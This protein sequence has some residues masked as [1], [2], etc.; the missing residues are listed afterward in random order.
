[1]LGFDKDNLNIALK[2]FQ[3]DCKARRVNKI[4]KGVCKKSFNYNDGYKFFTLNF[5]P[6]KLLN[7]KQKD[8]GLIT[9]YYEPILNGS[10][11]KTAK[12]KYPIYKTP[13]D[14]ITVRLSSIYPSLKRYALRGKIKGDKLVPYES[15]KELNK[16]NKK[17]DVLLY[18]DNKIDK[19]F[20]EIQGSGKVRLENKKIL[21]LAYAQQNGRKYYPIGRKLLKDGKILRKNMSLQAIK[22]WCE[23]N[24][25]EVDELLNLND[26]VVF[27][28]I[29]SKS[30]TG[31]LGVELVAKRNIAV[32]KDIIPLG[33]PVFLNTTNPISKKKINSLMISADTGGAIKGEIRA[34]YFWGDGS[35]AKLNAG[36]M[37]QKGKLTLLIPNET[38]K[39]ILWSNDTR[40][41]K[42]VKLDIVA[43]KGKNR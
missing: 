15:R 1:V 21:N 26:S 28:K 41:Y 27:F 43:K 2:V 25:L 9:G 11:T 13:K 6:Y 31:S 10:F 30:A 37:A 38:K 14:L 20:L 19:F 7:K 34:D 4:L 40:G 24:I 5:T 42:K 22:K 29:S 12:Y 33:F 18:V 32:D 8:I 17:L 39:V 35:E 23:N 3:K 16:N 36:K